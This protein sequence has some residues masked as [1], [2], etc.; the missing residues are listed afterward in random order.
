MTGIR[1]WALIVFFYALLALHLL[2]Q[3]WM[4]Y[5]TEYK[6]LEI[7]NYVAWDRQLMFI[8]LSL[9]MIFI[10]VIAI[11]S[12]LAFILNRH[13][14][15]V[16]FSAMIGCIIGAMLG[17][18]IM[19]FLVIFGQDVIGIRLVLIAITTGSMIGIYGGVKSEIEDDERVC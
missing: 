13:H 12:L 5:Y 1:Q 3:K 18:W 8:S 10:L 9:V 4:V 6:K 16:E 15:N 11:S 19:L 14:C 17:G 2:I 7:G